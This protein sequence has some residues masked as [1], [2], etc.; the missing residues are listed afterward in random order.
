MQNADQQ[1]QSLMNITDIQLNNSQF[2]G[3]EVQDL[4]LLSSDLSK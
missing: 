1:N 3:D 4:I 2:S